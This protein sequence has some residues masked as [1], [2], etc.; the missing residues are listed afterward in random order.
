MVL[1]GLAFADA[2]CPSQAEVS[3]KITFCSHNGLAVETAKTCASRIHAEW[4]KASQEIQKN[5]AE[6]KKASKDQQQNQLATSRASY[7]NTVKKLNDQIS[8][9]QRDTALVASYAQSMMDFPDSDEDEPPATCFTENF[10]KLQKIVGDLDKEIVQAKAV[11]KETLALQKTANTGTV[12]MSSIQASP[13]SP[14]K[15]GKESLP[16]KTPK[17]RDSD[18]S[19]IKENEATKAKERK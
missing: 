19:G 6:L 18:V 16:N 4:V 1:S 17:N 5:L 7:A 11:Y 8:S 14:Q 13:A 15:K 3:G 2:G 10:D 12:D 9:M